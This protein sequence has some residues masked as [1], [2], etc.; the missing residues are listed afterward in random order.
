M[1]GGRDLSLKQ[2]VA[3]LK[4]LRKYQGTQLESAGIELPKQAAPQIEAKEPSRT[5]TLEGGEVLLAFGKDDVDLRKRVKD[6]PGR[7]FDGNRKVWTVS[8]A[9]QSN[10]SVAELEAIITEFDASDEVKTAIDRLKKRDLNPH[11]IDVRAGKFEIEFPYDPTI[12]AA[13]RDLPGRRWV[14]SRKVNTVPLGSADHV[15]EFARKWGFR[16]SPEAEQALGG[17][18]K[19]AETLINLSKAAD[20]DL[21]ADVSSDLYPF[22]RA[23]V[24]Y[25]LEAER[26]LIGDQMGLGKTI[27]ALAA[28]QAAG[29]YPVVVV[30]PSSV[31]LNWK[32]EV[33]RWLPGRSVVAVH[34]YPE[35]NGNDE[36]NL[37]DHDVVIVN[38]AVLSRWMERLGDVAWEAVVLDESHYVKNHK[39]TRSKAAF[40]LAKD[41]RYRLLLTGTPVLN[42]PQEL[43]HQLKILDRL[44]DLGGFWGF[45][46]RYC[47]ARQ[48]RWGWDLSGAAHLEELNENLRR[49]C[50]V[51]RRKEDVLKELPAKRRVVVPVEIDNREQ[52]DDAEESLLA[53]FHEKAAEDPELQEVVSEMDIKQRRRMI[54]AWVVERYDRASKAEHLVRI[55]ALKQTAARGKLV[56]VRD[57]VRD[58]LE[59]GEKLVLFAVHQGIVESFAAEFDAPMIHGGVSAED[60]QEAIDRF[61]G[62]PGCKL[63][64]CNI[65]AGGVGITLTAASDVAFIELGWTPAEHD[66]AEDRVHRI[67][68]EE[69]VTAW[70]FRAE[71]TIEGEI[72]DL[73]G[74][75]RGVVDAVTD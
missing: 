66:Q 33:E 73:I 10:G 40:E 37:G 4:M 22:Q 8:L 63:I 69:S 7:R 75:K 57:W 45:A 67:G 60:R 34:G 61:Q 68:Q 18:I 44:D 29:A 15:T 43:I 54:A 23:G 11:K 2:R 31:K 32:R 16:L 21:D 24:A 70:Y 72:A 49:T 30:C 6:L 3:A 48:T 65:K 35:N 47:D 64:V 19:Q 42:R 26:V 41:T 36:I 25:A 55:E 52:Y 71:D 50:Y 28:V 1:Q 13:C 9:Q 17:V 14:K 59:S 74:R 12:V 51:R 46:K 56:A 5:A 27:E 53:W 58:F 20:A 62:D 38:Y 39:A